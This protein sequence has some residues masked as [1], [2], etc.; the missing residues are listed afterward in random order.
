MIT[1]DHVSFGYTHEK[2][3]LRNINL[4]I[5]A[6]ECVL[7]CGRSGCGK[8]TVTKIVNGLIPHFTESGCLQGTVTAAGMEVARTELYEWS[9]R[10]GSV[11]QNPKS[12][13]FNLDSDAE[14]AFGMENV[15]A[16]PG[17]HA[18]ETA[19]HCP[20]PENPLTSKKACFKG[21]YGTSIFAYMRAYRMNRAAV[22]LRAG[23]GKSVAEI[24]GRVGYDSP[25]KFA[26]A[27]KEVMGKSP[28]EYRKSF[29]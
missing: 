26:A 5:K 16:P 11:F 2:E 3:T 19:R 1:L 13:F 28:L 22:L 4:Y 23:G 6:G 21:V 9:Q 29:V 24:A 8:T 10:I 25:S 17:F 12:Q 14:L 7:L 20:G 27:F 18:A 15:G